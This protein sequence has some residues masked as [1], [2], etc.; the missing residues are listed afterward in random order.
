MDVALHPN[1]KNNKIIYFTIGVH[2]EGEKGGNT[3]LYRAKLN[4]NSLSNLKLLYKVNQIPKL[5][6]TGVQ[7]LF[8]MTKA[9][10]ILALEI[11]EIAMSIPKILIVTEENLS[12]KSRWKYSRRQ[13]IC[14]AKG[15]L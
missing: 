2:L 13:S 7:E 15:K 6:D 10:Y 14:Y 9:I 1:F 5:D 3:A 12:F 11:V 4:K 8:L